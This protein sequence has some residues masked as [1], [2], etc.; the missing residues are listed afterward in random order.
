MSASEPGESK[1]LNI[2]FGPSSTPF[3]FDK[4]KKVDGFVT[5]VNEDVKLHQR[6]DPKS[7]T[8]YGI[9]V[10]CEIPGTPPDQED[11]TP[12]A[13]VLTDTLTENTAE[14]IHMTYLLRSTKVVVDSLGC[15]NNPS[16]PSRPPA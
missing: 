7:V 10:K 9:Y 12:L 13:G 14:T 6:K 2:E 4:R 3:D 1:S 11:I 15:E 5:I 8:H 16:I